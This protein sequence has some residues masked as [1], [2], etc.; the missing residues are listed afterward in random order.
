VTRNVHALTLFELDRIL[1]GVREHRDEWA[2]AAPAS[3]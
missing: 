3:H 2:S 1:E